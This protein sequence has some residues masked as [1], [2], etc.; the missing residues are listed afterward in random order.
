MPWVGGETDGGVSLWPW[1]VE[2]R[3]GGR[4]AG[5][6]T[7]ASSS[8]HDKVPSCSGTKQNTSALVAR[9]SQAVWYSSGVRWRLSEAGALRGGSG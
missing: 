2:I 5:E 7:T 1:L 6:G 3:R 9:K 8:G 4:L